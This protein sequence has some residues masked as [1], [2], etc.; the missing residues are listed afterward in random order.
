M[1]K[2]DGNNRW[3]GKMMLTEHVEQYEQRHQPKLTGPATIDELHMIR[4]FA[5]YPHLIGMVQRSMDDLR[6]IKFTL[7]SLNM[8]CLEYLMMRL[9]DDFYAIKKEIR[10]RG[11]KV[12]DGEINDDVFYYNYVCRGYENRFGI[13]REK[14]RSDVIESLTKYTEEL[15]SRLKSTD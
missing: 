8:R 9:T 7:K 15:G 1:S 10:K 5:L 14:L 13:T 6:N 2:L 4:D 3:S 12:W 11:I